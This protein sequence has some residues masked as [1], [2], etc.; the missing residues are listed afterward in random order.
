MRKGNM[1]SV[2]YTSS[3]VDYIIVPI[4]SSKFPSSLL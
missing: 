3:L 4:S 1:G 2:T